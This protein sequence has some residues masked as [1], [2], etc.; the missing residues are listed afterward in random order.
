MWCLGA[1]L[2]ELLCGVPLVLPA[3]NPD[4][5]GCSEALDVRQRSLHRHVA[6]VLVRLLLLLHTAPELLSIISDLARPGLIQ[7]VYLAAAESLDATQS[8]SAVQHGCNQTIKI[9]P[10]F[11]AAFRRQVGGFIFISKRCCQSQ[12]ARG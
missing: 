5:R 10:V 3:G 11:V 8:R 1:L 4:A 6:A 2:V 9:P 7:S 12:H